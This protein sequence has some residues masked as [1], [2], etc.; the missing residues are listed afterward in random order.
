MKREISAKQ[1][2][3]NQLWLMANSKEAEFELFC[4]TND[5]KMEDPFS[6]KMFINEEAV[7]NKQNDNV[8]FYHNGFFVLWADIHG[9]YRIFTKS[10]H[11]ADMLCALFRRDDKIIWTE[12]YEV[13]NGTMSQVA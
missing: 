12:K 10:K 5:L 7:V 11:E 4:K 2:M 1:E 8:S 9:E 3:E 13:K 6:L